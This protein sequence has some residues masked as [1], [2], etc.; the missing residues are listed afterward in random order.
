MFDG[1]DN[2]TVRSQLGRFSWIQFLRCAVMSQPPAR[3][4]RPPPPP[5]GVYRLFPATATPA[6]RR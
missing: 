1:N 5:G 3:P 2:V 6:R 4:P